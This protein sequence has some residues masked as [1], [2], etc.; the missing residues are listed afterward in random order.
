MIGNVEPTKGNVIGNVEPT[1]GN[2]L[3]NVKPTKG[4]VIGNVE[5]RNRI[6]LDNVELPCNDTRGERPRLLHVPKSCP[7]FKALYTMYVYILTK[8]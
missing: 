3:G 7:M 8:N 6:T 4:N 1:K 5:L 2:V